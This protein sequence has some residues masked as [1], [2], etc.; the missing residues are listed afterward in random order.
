M[1]ITKAEL[2]E[3]FYNNEGKWLSRKEIIDKLVEKH[4]KNINI[5]K[6]NTH[7]NNFYNQNFI[8]K[9]VVNKHSMVEECLYVFKTSEDVKK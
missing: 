3:V 2:V 4:G 8:Y 5:K 9:K 7:L 6:V 1:M